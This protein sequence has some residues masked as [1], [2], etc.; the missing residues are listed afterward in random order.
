[1]VTRTR[2]AFV[3][4]VSK[5]IPG[6]SATTTPTPLTRASSGSG[7]VLLVPHD[8]RPRHGWSVLLLLPQQEE[9]EA[10]TDQRRAGGGPSLGYDIA[11]PRQHPVG[12]PDQS[13]RRQHDRHGR[14]AHRIVG[15]WAAGR[16]VHEVE[17]VDLAPHDLFGQL[18][19]PL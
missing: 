14:S 6:S 11:D 12:P 15:N 7:K 10:P 19:D 13:G 3:H 2:T 17:V 16:H 4:F 5:T 8:R 18:D 9:E 1:M